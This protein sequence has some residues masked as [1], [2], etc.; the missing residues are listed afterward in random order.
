MIQAPEASLALLDEL[1]EVQ[2]SVAKRA[3]ELRRKSGNDRVRDF[4]A[5]TESEVW[6]MRN[7]AGD[8]GRMRAAF[9]SEGCWAQ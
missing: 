7:D 4:W 1:T 5:E 3:D 8:R 9:W 6:A 2:F